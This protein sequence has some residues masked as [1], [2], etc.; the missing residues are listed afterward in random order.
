MLLLVSVD[1]YGVSVYVVQNWEQIT[2]WA[3][4]AY[5]FKTTL[6]T[7]N[8][9]YVHKILRNKQG[10]SQFIIHFDTLLLPRLHNKLTTV[11]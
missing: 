2:A 8:R 4:V 9:Q 11:A 1:A 5:L 7:S 3:A 6:P 10:T